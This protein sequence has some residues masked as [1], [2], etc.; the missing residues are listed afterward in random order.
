M[1]R[2]TKITLLEVFSKIEALDA[3]VRSK[4]NNKKTKA[5][6]TYDEMMSEPASNSTRCRIRPYH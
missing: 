5:C 2:K 3:I 6:V 1:L 4:F